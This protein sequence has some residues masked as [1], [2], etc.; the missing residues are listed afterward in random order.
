MA[1]LMVN[2]QSAI[3]S[4]R[5]T[6][7]DA[8]LVGLLVEMAHL[9]A[10]MRATFNAAYSYFASI[11]FSYGCTPHNW[12]YIYKKLKANQMD[13]IPSGNLIFIKSTAYFSSFWAISGC[14]SGRIRTS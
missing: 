6:E 2:V 13:F 11:N 12:E 14:I 5:S 3:K 4:L 1:K 8:Y 9:D 10:V 7:Y